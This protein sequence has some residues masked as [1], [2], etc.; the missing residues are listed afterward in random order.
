[1]LGIA[2]TA[3]H[4]SPHARAVLRPSSQNALFV[5]GVALERAGLTLDDAAEAVRTMHGPHRIPTLLA[6]V[7]QMARHGVRSAL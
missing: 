2:K 3:F 5:T 1:M 6:C 7:D 4:G